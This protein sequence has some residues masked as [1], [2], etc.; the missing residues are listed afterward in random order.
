MG[1]ANIQQVGGLAIDPENE[2]RVFVAALGHPYGPNG[3]YGVYRTTD[4][5][6]TWDRVLY[7]DE[8]TAAAMWAA[9]RA[10]WENG[11]W[12]GGE[13]GLYKSIDGGNIWNKITKGLPTKEGLTPIGFG[14]ALSDPQR[15]YATVDCG[16]QG[17]IYRSNDAGESWTLINTDERC[18]G[19]GEDFAEIKVDPD[20]HVE[21]IH[22]K[23]VK[24]GQNRSGQ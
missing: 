23:M 19:R 21:G 3:E 4:G 24:N 10:P 8:N 13:S 12:N 20:N 18:W 17:G 6:K 14:I 15:L 9:R 22:S 7:K 5:G 16:N 2:N 11:K 1:L